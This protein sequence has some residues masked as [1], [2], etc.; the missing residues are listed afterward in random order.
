MTYLRWICTLNLRFQYLDQS[1]NGWFRQ[2]TSCSRVSKAFGADILR[3]LHRLA[4][5]GLIL[6]L[7]RL[8]LLQSL[9][10]HLLLLLLFDLEGISLTWCPRQILLCLLIRI[11]WT[12]IELIQILIACQFMRSFYPITC[13]DM[14]FLI[15]ITQLSF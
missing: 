8:K 14:L 2:Y 4:R 15:Q 10:N 7:H 12:L 1:H 3:N 6:I 5:S 13:L 11:A 9:L